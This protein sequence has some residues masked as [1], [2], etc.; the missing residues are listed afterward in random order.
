MRLEWIIRARSKRQSIIEYIAEDNFDAALR[1][2]AKLQEVAESLLIFP[3]KG[4]EGR[5]RGT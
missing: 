2:D 5:I 4:A 3:K 1:M